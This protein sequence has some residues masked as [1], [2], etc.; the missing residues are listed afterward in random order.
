[1][2]ILATKLHLPL[3]R[4]RTV[5]RTRLLDQLN[6]GLEHK[7]KLTLI[8]APAGFGK[9]TLASEW[10]LGCKQPVAWLSLDE[11]D[12]DLKRFLNYLVAALQTIFPEIGMNLLGALQAS[13]I[14]DPESLLTALINEIDSIPNKF[15]FVLDDYHM[16]DSKLVDQALNFL[17]EHLPPQMHLVITTREDPSLPCGQ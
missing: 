13:H 4:S 7:H 11:A 3:P 8:S 5:L 1:M 14:P 12:G 17:V 2:S 9:T 6:A 10:V 15:I 16:L